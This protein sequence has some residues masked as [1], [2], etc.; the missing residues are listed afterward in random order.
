M[1]HRV[2]NRDGCYTHVGHPTHCQLRKDLASIYTRTHAYSYA[3]AAR[4]I[5]RSSH[6]EIEQ[7]QERN[8]TM[9]TATYGRTSSEEQ[10]ATSIDDQLRNCKA[11]AAREGLTIDPSLYFSDEAITGKA[12]GNKRRAGYRRLLDAIEAG[13]CT[14]VVVDE[15]SRLTRAFGEGGRLI[16]VVTEQGLRIITGDGIDTNREGWKMLWTMKLMSAVQEVDS[17]SARTT[18]G[19]LGTLH[20]GFQIAQPPFGYRSFAVKVPG[21]RTACAM[22]EI[23]EPQASIVQRIFQ[24][25]QGGQSIAGIARTLNDDGILPPRVSRCKAKPYWRPGTVYRLLNNTIYRGVFTWNGSSFV[26]AIAR[27]KR[28]TVVTEDFARE[29]L[30]LVS[31]E[32]WYA[33][34]QRQDT[35]AGKPP[36]GPRGGGKHLFSGLMHC[37]YCN[38]L[39]SVGGGPKSFSLYCAQCEIAKRTGGLDKWIGYSSV[40]SARH[41]LEFALRLLFTDTVLAEFHSRLKERLLRGPAAEHKELRDKANKLTDTVAR[42]KALIANPDLGPELFLDDL[43]RTNDELRVVNHKLTALQSQMTA[44]T[45]MVLEAQLTLNPLALIL[46]LLSSNEEVYKLRATLRRLIERFELISRPNSTSSVFRIRFTPG[47]C[48]AELSETPVLDSTTFAF[49]ITVSCTK[50]R[51]TAWTVTGQRI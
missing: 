26:K 10:R 22:W 49:E 17:S 41:A 25:R 33:C 45:P 27:R 15:L 13:I 43:V 14:V 32:V 9:P 16:D 28:K 31:D 7:Q 35:G 51:P 50:A 44:L 2:A 4:P 19:M 24:L 38:A 6:Q 40:S 42:L 46:E 34:N 20:R 5:G 1:P 37:A 23:H 36:R 29:N 30:R 18:R 11:I 12:S 3:R 21:N 48:V 47:V 39:L 8:Q